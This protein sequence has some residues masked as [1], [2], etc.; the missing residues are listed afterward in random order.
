MATPRFLKA[1]ID[2]S[3]RG[4]LGRTSSGGSRRRRTRLHEHVA[5]VNGAPVLDDLPACA[6]P[7][8]DPSDPD[9]AFLHP[10]VVNII[11]VVMVFAGAIISIMM[12][13]GLVIAR[14]A[15]R[16]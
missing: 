9:A 15:V 1:D 4:T 5:H 16:N 13:W 8:L 7:H 14:K 2:T 6:P 11:E 10:G 12:A 3:A